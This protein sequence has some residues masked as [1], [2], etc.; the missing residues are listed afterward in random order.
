[1]KQLLV[2]STTCALMQGKLP[3]DCNEY[4]QVGDYAF[5]KQNSV[6]V[7]ETCAAYIQDHD[8]PRRLLAAECLYKLNSTAKVS[9]FGNLLDAIE[10]EKDDAVREALCWAAMGAEAVTAKLDDRALALTQKLAADPKSAT[11]AGWLFHSMFPQYLMGKG[12]KPPAKAQAYALEALKQDNTPVQRAALDAVSLLDDKAAVC[13]AL[14]GNLRADAKNWSGSADAIAAM[15]DACVA[16]LAKTIDFVLERLKAGDD[17]IRVLSRYDYVFDL[18]A[19]T[20]AKIAKAIRAAKAKAPEW[21]RKEFDETAGK[22]E[23]PPVKRK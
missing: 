22:F 20:R 14:D 23:K 1:M 18:D 5:L 12:P 15:K 7:A 16:N 6:D 21:Q 19:P 3:L 11:A 4:K 8:V 10:V 17:N 13:A 2:K 9:V